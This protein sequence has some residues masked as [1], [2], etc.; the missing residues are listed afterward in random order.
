M[1]EGANQ[2]A[3]QIRTAHCTLARE[4]AYL[5]WGPSPLSR[6]LKGELERIKNRPAPCALVRMQQAFGNKSL[7]SSPVGMEGSRIDLH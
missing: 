3:L 4:A 7:C 5:Q 2:T 6:M 1:Q